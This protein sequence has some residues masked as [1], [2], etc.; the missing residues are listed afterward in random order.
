M[1][2]SAAPGTARPGSAGGWRRSEA[3]TARIVPRPR[4]SDL[5][6]ACGP[7]WPLRGPSLPPGRPPPSAHP[8]AHP[9]AGPA[10]AGH[11]RRWLSSRRR[12]PSGTAL[13]APQR[14]G[15]SGRLCSAAPA[16]P[17]P[18]QPAAPRGGDGAGPRG[19]GGRARGVAVPRAGPRAVPV[20]V[21]PPLPVAP[22]ALTRGSHYGGG[23]GPVRGASP[24]SLP[25]PRFCP[26]PLRPAPR[27]A[28]TA[29][30]TGRRTRK[31]RNEWNYN[32]R[33]VP[34]RTP[35]WLI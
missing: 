30:P 11:G 4:R 9:H 8:P 13:P 7:S 29:S 18:R 32:F 14:R 2:L 26:A 33:H 3:S 24:L 12:R 27:H 19:R 23:S 25:R 6:Q 28:G 15:R 34:R 31:G 35:R 16:Q 21:P 22:P 17:G 10:G 5:P 1:P 20:P